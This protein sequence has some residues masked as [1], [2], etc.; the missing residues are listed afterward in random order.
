MAPSE[1]ACDA[2]HVGTS[3]DADALGLGDFS[4]S[5]IPGIVGQ[6]E[7]RTDRPSGDDSCAAVIVRH[8]VGMTVPNAEPTT[9]PAAPDAIIV[10]PFAMI[11]VIIAV[12]V[13]LVDH[14]GACT[15]DP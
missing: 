3:V 1:H 15:L 11:V 12:L 6:L 14:Q 8:V 2:S 13:P 7:F 9:T 5:G 4:F 10:Q